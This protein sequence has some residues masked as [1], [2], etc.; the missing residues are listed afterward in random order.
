MIV[1]NSCKEKDSHGNNFMS[2]AKKVFGH[3]TFTHMVGVDVNVI[4]GNIASKSDFAVGQQVAF[5]T[6]EGKHRLHFTGTIKKLNAEV[7]IIVTTTGQNAKVSYSR[8]RHAA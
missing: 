2:I 6:G 8:L 1:H 4:D 3:V 7:A 5:T